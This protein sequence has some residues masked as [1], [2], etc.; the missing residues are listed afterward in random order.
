MQWFRKFNFMIFFLI[1]GSDKNDTSLLRTATMDD[2]N[3]SN[4]WSKTEDFFILRTEE[5]CNTDTF[6]KA[7]VKLLTA[8]SSN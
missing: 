5:A 1:C 8:Y 7:K 4:S 6:S 3:L 2:T